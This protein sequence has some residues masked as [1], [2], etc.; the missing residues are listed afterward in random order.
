MFDGRMS[1]GGRDVTMVSDERVD[2]YD[3]DQVR[4][5]GRIFSC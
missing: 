2:C 5:L 1:C 4:P 3:D